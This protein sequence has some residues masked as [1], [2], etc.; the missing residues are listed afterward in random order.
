MELVRIQPDKNQVFI[1]ALLFSLSQWPDPENRGD[2]CN[3]H[4]DLQ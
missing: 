4:Y 1:V 2:T 3:K